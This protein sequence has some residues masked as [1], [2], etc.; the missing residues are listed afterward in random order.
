MSNE[1]DYQHVS[2]AL[3]PGESDS[4]KAFMSNLE[5][6]DQI[7]GQIVDKLV[8]YLG[9]KVISNYLPANE[10][11]RKQ[12]IEENGKTL[13]LLVLD[14]FEHNQIKLIC[15]ELIKQ[16]KSKGLENTPS[17]Q[18]LPEYDPLS[19]LYIRI[20][21]QN[22]QEADNY[23]ANA[24]YVDH[25]NIAT[26]WR[27]NCDIAPHKVILCADSS[28]VIS[29]TLEH[30]RK[31]TV[32]DL[33]KALPNYCMS[34][35]EDFY[36]SYGFKSYHAEDIKTKNPLMAALSVL[37]DD[38]EPFSVKLSFIAKYFIYAWY[39]YSKK[40]CSMESALGTAL[41][42][43]NWP[44]NAQL[45]AKVQ[46]NAKTN[47][48]K[49]FSANLKQYYKETSSFMIGKVDDKNPLNVEKLLSNYE[50]YYF[51]HEDE[52][53]D[54]NSALVSLEP[55]EH[56]FVKTYLDSFGKF[57]EEYNNAYFNLC[58]I[59]WEKLNYL[60]AEV[61]TK[62][63]KET[64]LEQTIRLFEEHSESEGDLL[65]AE[66][67]DSVE[68]LL[69]STGKNLD[70]EQRDELY[71]ILKQKI[72]IFNQ[73]SKVK[74]AWEKLIFSGQALNDEDFILA[75][76][77]A[78]INILPSQNNAE[79]SVASVTLKLERSLKKLLDTNYYVGCYFSLRFGSS[80]RE[81]FNR[82]NVGNHERFVL[83]Y[84]PNQGRAKNNQESQTASLDHHPLINF[85]NFFNAQQAAKPDLKRSS[86]QSKDATSYKFYL[87]PTF[88]NGEVGKRCIIEWHF[89]V[90]SIGYYLFKDLENVLKNKCLQ[91]GV[92]AR[93]AFSVQ[94]YEQALN[95]KDKSTFLPV[96]RL[97]TGQL[98]NK[99]PSN[100]YNVSESFNKLCSK[101]S[102]IFKEQQGEGLH[103]SQVESFNQ[104]LVK[105]KES[106]SV[107]E[108]TYLKVLQSL[109]DCKLNYDCVRLMT[110]QASIVSFNIMNASFAQEHSKIKNLTLALL[111]CFN[112]VG[113]AFYEH[114]EPRYNSLL[115]EQKA[116][117]NTILSNSDACAIATPLAVS[118]LSNFV[119]KH[120]RMVD[121]IINAFNNAVLVNDR[122]LLKDSYEAELKLGDGNE[123]IFINCKDSSSSNNVLVS[124]QALN[125][126]TLYESPESIKQDFAVS[127]SS[128]KGQTRKKSDSNKLN[129]KAYED[130]A[131]SFIERYIKARPYL[132]EQCTI[133]IYY[134]GVVQLPLAIYK[135]LL[136]QKSLAAIKF[137]LIIVNCSVDDSAQIY[138]S[139][140]D[141]RLKVGPSNED[142]SYEQR[143][144][145]SILADHVNQQDSSEKNGVIS[146]DRT[147]SSSDGSFN[148]FLNR[149][150]FKTN[151][152][153]SANNAALD[154]IADIC[155]M[156]HVFDSQATFGFSNTSN[157]Y[158]VENGL[159]NVKSL[160]SYA[161]QDGV[162]SR[163]VGKFL[164]CPVLTDN[165]AI[166]LHGLYFLSQKD[167]G[168]FNQVKDSLA[169]ISCK[170]KLKESDYALSLDLAPKGQNRQSIFVPLFELKTKDDENVG[171]NLLDSVFKRC[172]TVL[173]MDELMCRQLLNHNEIKIVYHQKLKDLDLNLLGACKEYSKQSA[174]FINN[175]LDKLD[176]NDEQK[177]TDLITRIVSD[178]AD[179]SGS[180]VIRSQL[181]RKRTYEM[182]GLVL[183]QYIVAQAFKVIAQRLDCTSPLGTASFVSLDD[184][185]ALIGQKEGKVADIL[186]LQVLKYKSKAQVQTQAK[187]E[188]STT[189]NSGD[190]NSLDLL[191]NATLQANPLFVDCDL[192]AK[193]AQ[194]STAINEYVLV[195][196]IIESKFF[197]GKEANALKKSKDQ[198]RSSLEV[199]YEA[200]RD[201]NGNQILDRKIMLSKLANL[202]QYSSY[203]LN[204]DKAQEFAKIQQLISSEQIDILIKGTS[205]F[206]A[207]NS[208]DISNKVTAGINVSIDP[209]MDKQ[210]EDKSIPITQLTIT[211]HALKDVVN[212]FYAQDNKAS[213]NCQSDS[214]VDYIFKQDQEDIFKRYLNVKSSEILHLTPNA[215][216]PGVTVRTQDQSGAQD[217][218]TSNQGNGS[219]N[220]ANE[221]KAKD[222]ASPVAPDN[223]GLTTGSKETNE[224]SA[225]QE[226]QTAS[227]GNANE[228]ETEAKAPALPVAPENGGL[229]TGSKETNEPSA[230]QENQTASQGN[231]N[232]TEAKAPAL[233]VAPE[234]G[235]LTTGSEETKVPSVPQE[236]HTTNQGNANG[237][238][239][240]QTE[241]KV[242][243]APENGGMITS[244][245]QE[246]E[247]SAESSVKAENNGSAQLATPAVKL[248]PKFEIHS[249]KQDDKQQQSASSNNE[250]LKIHEF[251][252]EHPKV[253]KLIESSSQIFDDKEQL[254][255]I[256]FENN[257][258]A[259]IQALKDKGIDPVLTKKK[260]TC[261]GAIFSFDGT[262]NF[263][264]SKIK[265]SDKQYF[266]TKYKVDIVELRPKPGE[267][268]VYVKFKH[269]AFV[270]YLSLLKGHDFNFD[271]YEFDGETYRGFNSKFIL[272]LGEETGATVYLDLRKDS[273]H[274]LI[275]G[276]TGSGKS[277]C[278]NTLLLDMVLTNLHNEL[279]IILVDPKG[280]A[281]FF[282]FK[283][284]PHLKKYGLITNQKEALE[285]IELL[286]D[287]MEERYQEFTSL[288][289]FIQS[290]G[291][292]LKS[293]INTIDAY[294]KI[295]CQYQR[296]R[297]P[298]IFF[299]MDEFADW[300]GDDSFRKRASEYVN[301]LASKARAAGIH[302]IL[303]TQRPDAKIMEGSIKGQ[304]DN[305][306]CLKTTDSIN[307]KIILGDNEF[308]A[309]KLSGN[310]HMICK[311]STTSTAQ[312]GYIDGGKLSDM[313]QRIIEDYED[314][315]KVSN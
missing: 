272:G 219:G 193:E 6:T 189:T 187:L 169:A 220:V 36:K 4:L 142:N 93:N 129:S 72:H 287:I 55:Y 210:R 290:Q 23:Y 153:S 118:S 279:E 278:L 235:G 213:E 194:K 29:D 291:H 212:N 19:C 162:K 298:H 51:H 230:P 185:A 63:K 177:R 267:I 286:V 25:D 86:S 283:N 103:Y 158:L 218:H 305:R 280:G 224:P 231:A 245:E 76:A 132:S 3:E 178:A 281:E 67:W 62:Q 74:N 44:A 236:Q 157:A 248:P 314:R 259:L 130:A 275:G 237:N 295:C 154:K 207:L 258:K 59:D 28:S 92:F 229:T 79:L 254:R 250:P 14:E 141:E 304:L 47:V 7:I 188:N 138:K 303:A 75:L 163:Y 1:L 114:Y 8:A 171:A 226:N 24:P 180:I 251:W 179:I 69:K 17:D 105:I 151:G 208:R 83:K 65:D 206:Y 282:F 167:I 35:I 87:E 49:S 199:F 202:L 21:Y 243:V 46:S 96:Q 99:Q 135:R 2:L 309:S 124:R 127:T 12:Q 16:M 32:D 128:S 289:A 255:L 265:E 134:C 104:D 68:P 174:G 172:E 112:S 192:S 200:I 253:W 225:P 270:S 175:L 97:A 60:F 195:V 119:I 94:G 292:Q 77:K 263:D 84:T 215:D 242:H 173:F 310:G 139:F 165:E 120:K 312:G 66:Q 285:K 106:F 100:L 201:Q 145:V 241:A 82:V 33:R 246:G 40:E 123:T 294:N 260:L 205:F 198:T 311:L 34:F 58:L 216:Q 297:L 126:Y 39:L 80:L 183:C 89:D 101:L 293:I 252:A 184:Y 54:K 306:I 136:E 277:V 143:I 88:A 261:N 268:D 78:F 273:P 284:L 148:H 38:K 238:A 222:P 70:Q 81:I 300:F 161:D 191:D 244:A 164:S 190:F 228:T 137:H 159:D 61:K 155:L 276:S 111:E 22:V 274:T 203:K 150:S 110:D 52:T 117:N 53:G 262:G 125:G 56:A 48:F 181:Y 307:S 144:K 140:E 182:M 30:I 288:M 211:D 256:E 109:H 85:A 122:Q 166:Y 90:K 73:S 11:E 264:L 227:Q 234:N 204:G 64:L 239:A 10:L 257:E 247:Q 313:I 20:H 107:F 186:G 102:D 315:L 217:Q 296:G 131:L 50:L 197:T 113:M 121:F 269:R 91:V 209:S 168:C 249:P 233:P 240:N 13:G 116:I 271:F 308:D 15:D 176:N 146:F 170:A 301:R 31:I 196:Y 149:Y 223:G 45:F 221:T 18:Y 302:L 9:V 108:S 43:L 152:N 41:C 95:L 133:L 27:N 232:E 37:I 5:I 147:T 98:F 266:L 57:T 156:F 299:V 42:V 26:W 214:V 160:V 115:N 71:E